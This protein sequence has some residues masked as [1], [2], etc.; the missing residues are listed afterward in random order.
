M[1]GVISLSMVHVLV[2]ACTKVASVYK[3]WFGRRKVV[4]PSYGGESGETSSLYML[5]SP[6]T[7]GSNIEK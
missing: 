1:Q 3:T 4:W 6:V 5:D 2:L 7:G